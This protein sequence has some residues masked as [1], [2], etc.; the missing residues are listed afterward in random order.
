MNE[1]PHREGIARLILDLVL[2]NLQGNT[3][4]SSAEYGQT[5]VVGNKHVV[6]IELLSADMLHLSVNRGDSRVAVDGKTSTRPEETVLIEGERGVSLHGSEIV[7]VVEVIGV[8]LVHDGR[9]DIKGSDNI[10]YGTAESE[11]HGAHNES[12]QNKDDGEVVAKRSSE[13]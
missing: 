3:E 7:V 4:R 1:L 13:I 6:A 2:S 5:S 12:T 8:E 10:R 9:L 11:T